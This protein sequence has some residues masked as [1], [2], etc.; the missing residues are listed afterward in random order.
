MI[1]QSVI[2]DVGRVLFDW[3]LRH[4]FAKLIADEAELEWFVTHVV[5]PQWHFQHDAGR[6]LTDMLPERKAEME[7]LRVLHLAATTWQHEVEAGL[8][9]LLDEGQ[10]PTFTAVS[11]L[12]SNR[13][14]EFPQM[15]PLVVDLTGYDELLT[16]EV[17]P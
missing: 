7:Y 15:A 16:V 8:E 9:L 12:C 4:L 1:R 14:P 6:P 3:D 10:L 17:S 2:F 5:T 13:K 11:A